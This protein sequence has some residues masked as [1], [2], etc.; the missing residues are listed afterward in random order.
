VGVNPEP[1]IVE[2]PPLDRRADVGHVNA[3]TRTVDL[4]FST[5]AAVDRTDYWTGKR[6]REVLSMDPKAVRLDRLNAGAPLLDSHSSYSLDSVMG[7]VVDGSASVSKGAGRASVR[8]SKRAAVDPVFQDVTDGII[9][10][11]SVG[12]R[13]HKFEESQGADGVLV[14][15][16]LDWEPYEVSLVAMPA[17]VGARVRS[18]DKG[19]DVNLCVIVTREVS[20]DTSMATE[21][22]AAPTTEPPATPATRAAEPAAP[23]APAVDVAAVRAEERARA[24]TIRTSAKV[25]GLVDEAF[26]DGLIGSDK[27]LD[28][29]RAEIINELEA[30]QRKTPNT[31]HRHTAG[32]VAGED[33]R[34]KFGRGVGA[35]LLHKAGLAPQFARLAEQGKV[36]KLEDPGEYRGLSLMDLARLCLDRAN[37]R[38]RGLDKMQVAALAFT[39]RDGGIMQSTSDF[40]VLLENVMH[41]VLQMAYGITPDTWRR[42][43]AQSTVPDFRASSR[44]RMGSLSVLDSLTENGEFKNKPINDVEKATITATTKGNIIG[45][46]RAMIVNDD[47]AAFTRL[48]SMLGRAAALSIEADVYNLI[49]LNSG[50]GPTQSDS[51]PLFHANRSNVSTGAALS[52]AAIDADRVVMAQQK[53]PNGND[54]TNLKPSILLVPIGLGGVARVI[55]I[56]QYDP[57]NISGASSKATMKPNVVAGLF[58]D[59]VDT[60]RLTGTRRYLFADPSQAPVIEVAFLEGAPAPVLE[61]QDGWRS[62]GAEMRV[63]F[64]YGVA[65]IDW[66]GAVTNAGV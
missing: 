49:G 18:G 2:L 46:T 58:A 33:E 14:R 57:D 12:Y 6:Y 61:S 48:L 35:W 19:T 62:D 37:V 30:R 7:A 11:V 60:P 23:A 13:V 32:I 10:S 31:D 56:S 44:Y 36:D 28:A 29:C 42:F 47:M 25:V 51:Q 59:V 38:T 8:F 50:L 63:R 22:K 27:S 45:I 24:L 66:R 1:Q 16:A 34:D 40:A 65:A 52:A 4:V 5:G 21:T 15:T 9:R 43:C 17:D 20:E 39:T 26:V 41:K 53:E 55:N 54:Y 3:D 64:D